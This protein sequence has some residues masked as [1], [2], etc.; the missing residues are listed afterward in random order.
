MEIPAKVSVFN[1]QL[2]FKG[3]TGTLISIN[4]GFYEI[5]LEVQQRN[6][7][8][9]FPIEQTVVVFNEAIPNISADFE[10]ER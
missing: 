6:H 3:K 2:Q 9:L 5:V 10:V 1:E 7:T 8:V 4:D